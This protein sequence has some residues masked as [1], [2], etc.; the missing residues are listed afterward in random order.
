MKNSYSGPIVNIG[1]RTNDADWYTIKEYN[2]S[3]DKRICKVEHINGEVVFNENT[4]D[5]G[6]RKNVSDSTKRDNPVYVEYGDRVTYTVAI[7]N[8]SD[9]DYYSCSKSSDPY[10]MPQYVTLDLNGILPQ[11]YSDLTIKDGTTDV[12]YEKNNNRYYYF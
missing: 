3:I 1:T 6:F 4:T 2:I 11:N 7:Y 12:T 9:N 8:T 5:S 10:M